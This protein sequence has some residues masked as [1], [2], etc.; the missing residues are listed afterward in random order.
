M[1]RKG[2]KDTSAAD[3]QTR[4]ELENARKNRAHATLKKNLSRRESAVIDNEA[5]VLSR[6]ILVAA[7]EKV[8]DLRDDV[9]RLRD[10]EAQLSL[11]HI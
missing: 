2:I 1:K 5:A 4:L 8:A 6:E 11:I 3:D 9:A 7:R 10:T